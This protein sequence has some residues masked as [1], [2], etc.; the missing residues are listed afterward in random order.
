MCLSHLFCLFFLLYIYHFLDIKTI[1]L[2][3]QI[4]KVYPTLFSTL[5]EVK[6]AHH[7]RGRDDSS[8]W[9]YIL[10][11]NQKMVALLSH[12]TK[13]LET[14]FNIWLTLSALTLISPSDNTSEYNTKSYIQNLAIEGKM[15]HKTNVLWFWVL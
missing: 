15:T 1:S 8:F 6:T 3:S 13:Q 2:K 12:T 10:K 9:D 7:L 14:H 5:V 11:N 4:Q